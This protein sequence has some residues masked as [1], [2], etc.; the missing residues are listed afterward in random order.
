MC[1]LSVDVYLQC[2]EGLCSHNSDLICTSG[3]HTHSHTRSQCPCYQSSN[4]SIQPTFPLFNLS[5]AFIAQTSFHPS[6]CASTPKLHCNPIGLISSLSPLHTPTPPAH[7][8]S[9]ALGLN[10]LLKAETDAKR[11][12]WKLLTADTLC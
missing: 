9:A 3:E 11:F 5:T 6:V 2:P 10:G 7:L 4:P 1:R 8:H 12:R